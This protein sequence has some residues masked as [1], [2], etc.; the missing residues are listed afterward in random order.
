MR[1]DRRQRPLPRK[2]QHLRQTRQ[3][4]RRNTL[5]DHVA[6]VAK[7]NGFGQ[8]LRGS[9]LRRVGA[10]EVADLLPDLSAVNVDSDDVAAAFEPQQLLGD[11][12]GA[13]HDA[14]R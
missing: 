10:E 11:A 3:Q 8:R 9:L 2:P 5:G 1:R 13:G 14:V 12:A 4:G 6:G 7:Q